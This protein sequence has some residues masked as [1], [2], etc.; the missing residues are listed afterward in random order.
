MK[1]EFTKKGEGVGSSYDKWLFSFSYHTYNEEQR[2]A[3]SFVERFSLYS[4]SWVR[5]SSW[6]DVT[7]VFD[8]HLRT[9]VIYLFTFPFIAFSFICSFLKAMDLKN[10][11]PFE[12]LGQWLGIILGCSRT[13]LGLVTVSALF[14]QVMAFHF[15]IFTSTKWKEYYMRNEELQSKRIQIISGIIFRSVILTILWW[16][17]VKS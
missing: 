1:L 11:F 12:T 13:L 2:L 17:L 4:V 9:S 16:Q 14:S 8:Q 7:N 3:M 15:S 6:M 5:V 10:Y